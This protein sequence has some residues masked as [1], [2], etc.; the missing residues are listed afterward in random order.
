MS[1]KN[2]K[3]IPCKEDEHDWDL[4]Y[5]SSFSHSNAI[6]RTKCGLTKGTESFYSEKFDDVDVEIWKD[7]D[8]KDWNACI[9]MKRESLCTHCNDGVET[10]DYC[11]IELTKEQVKKWIDILRRF[12][13]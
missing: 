9:S 8:G 13:E 6:S 5:M 12:F 10:T 3:T 7:F 11:E 2:E 1:E 4:N